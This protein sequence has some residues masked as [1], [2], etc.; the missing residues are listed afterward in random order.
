MFKAREVNY[1][2]V[3]VG[4]G[5]VKMDPAKIK[6]VKDWPIPKTKHQLQAFPEFCNFY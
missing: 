3:I 5:T 6:A 2:G 4:N 1:L